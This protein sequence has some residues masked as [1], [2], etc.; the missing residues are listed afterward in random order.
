MQRHLYHKWIQLYGAQKW[1]I[2]NDVSTVEMKL[3]IEYLQ[4]NV[5]YTKIKASSNW[6]LKMSICLVLYFN[7]PETILKLIIDT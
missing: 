1:S 6:T 3:K 4:K 2:L 7:E 5:Q